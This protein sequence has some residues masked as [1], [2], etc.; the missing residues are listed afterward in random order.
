MTQ[1]HEFERNGISYLVGVR[2][3]SGAGPIITQAS[4]V[5]NKASLIDA[6]VLDVDAARFVRDELTRWLR[7]NGHEG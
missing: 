3:G 2:R 1:Y 6:I 4:R 5:D 7:Q